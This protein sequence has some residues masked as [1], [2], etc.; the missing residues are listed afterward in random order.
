MLNQISIYIFLSFFV[1]LGYFFYE[2]GGK[3]LS[4]DFFRPYYAMSSLIFLY[5][6][7]HLLHIN[8]YQI[9]HYGNPIPSITEINIFIAVTIVG[10]LGLQFGT[11]LA[12]KRGE[13]EI[14]NDPGNSLLAK[15][16]MFIF[17]L[18]SIFNIKKYFFKFNIF[19]AT[20]YAKT[21]TSLRLQNAQNLNSG[22]IE[23]I[24][25]QIPTI[26]ILTRSIIILLNKKI[27]I[28]YRLLFL[29][30]I[31]FY[32][33]TSW[34]SGWRIEFLFLFV[35]FLIYY[36]YK[37]KPIR[38]KW[39]I[40]F[41]FLAFFAA[42]VSS[43]L[44]AGNE[45]LSSQFSSRGFDL[46]SIENISELNTSANL[47]LLI[48]KINT[49]ES[50][51]KYGAILLSQIKAFAPRFL[52]EKRSQTGAEIFSETF[53]PVQFSKGAG[54][55]FYILQEGY[56]DF[57]ILG[58]LIYMCLTGYFLERIYIIF[59]KIKKVSSLTVALYGIFYFY[60]AVASIRGGMVINFKGFL[61]TSSPILISILLPLLLQ[62]YMKITR[63]IFNK[64]A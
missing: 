10:I 61:L 58:V 63:K 33:L 34:K 54:F 22:L 17:L 3:K 37:I 26:T 27:K 4:L 39:I 60:C 16:M 21:A 64:S 52:V 41:F 12:K 53:F 59:N 25:V 40:L 24:Y 44:R 50:S 55:G 35:F 1:I 14:K 38:I 9:D 15:S 29:I 51:Y 36:H 6:L 11:A 56:W 13:L 62:C 28:F 20:T 7:G 8:R 31:I 32:F 46:F 45:S 5:S 18:W 42:S 57:G 47:G 48:H 23:T 43:Y 19:E 30:P 2:S 49:K